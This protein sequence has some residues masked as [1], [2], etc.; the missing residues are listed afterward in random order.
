MDRR[1]DDRL[2][3]A[4][5]VDV[6]RID[7]VDAGVRRMRDDLVRG[8]R[9]GAIAEHHRAETNDRDLEPAFTET[10]ELHREHPH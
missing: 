1:A 4:F 2:G 5:R 7:E 3:C 8:R 6:G 10:A 9:I